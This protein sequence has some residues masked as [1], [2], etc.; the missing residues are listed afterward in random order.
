[1]LVLSCKEACTT[2]YFEPWKSLAWRTCT[3]IVGIPLYV[4]NV[5]YPL[6][7]EELVRFLLKQESN[8]GD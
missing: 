3:A 6:I 4:M 8:L 5:T 2:A 7:D 1:M